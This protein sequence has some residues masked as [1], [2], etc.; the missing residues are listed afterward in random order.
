[1]YSDFA[2]ETG[3]W[4]K[5]R[6]LQAAVFLPV[7]HYPRLGNLRSHDAGTRGAG[8]LALSAPDEISSLCYCV[9][10]SLRGLK[11]MTATSGP[12]WAL[13]A[14]TVQYALITETPVVIALVQ[15]LSPS[16]EGA[17][18]GAQGDIFL[19]GI[20]T[21]GGYTIQFRLQQPPVLELLSRVQLVGTPASPV[22]T[23]LR[24]GSGHDNRSGG[25]SRLARLATVER[26]R[27]APKLPSLHMTSRDLKKCRPL[28]R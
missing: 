22:R 2:L 19:A 13:M 26:S 18:Q 14:E 17:T 10:A 24:Q 1:M 28:L 12:G 7:I 25:G 3:W 15:R 11:A 4:P 9:G 23:A 27:S 20:S 5:A 21:S 6:L 16:A 8:R